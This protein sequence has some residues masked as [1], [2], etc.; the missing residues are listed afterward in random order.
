MQLASDMAAP[1]AGIQSSLHLPVL[2]LNSYIAISII[3]A[4]LIVHGLVHLMGFA[5]AFGYASLPQL[6][7]PISRQ[8]GLVW[9]L[10]GLLVCASAVLLVARPRMGWIVGAMALIVSQTVIIAAWRD[11]WAGTLVNVVL[12]LVVVYAFLTEDRSA[13]GRSSIVMSPPDFPELSQRVS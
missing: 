3:A 10:A 9:L 5:K 8:A 6:T 13:S 4:L 1:I 2:S 7:Q 12:V 11:A